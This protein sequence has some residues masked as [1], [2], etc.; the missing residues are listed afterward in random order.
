MNK[1]KVGSHIL[2]KKKLFYLILIFLFASF[3]G[4]FLFHSLES[5][6][7]LS[8]FTSQ[9]YQV[10]ISYPSS[11]KPISFDETQTE[12]HSFESSVGFFSLSTKINSESLSLLEICNKELASTLNDFGSTPQIQ[13]F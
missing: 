5:P 9:V 6:N 11:W 2:I 12:P 7:T 10:K 3:G 1:N 8:S 4:F 13:K